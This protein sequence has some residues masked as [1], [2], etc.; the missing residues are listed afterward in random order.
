MIDDYEEENG[1]SM[2]V[3]DFRGIP[4]D[5]YIDMLD[6]IDRTPDEPAGM[7]MRYIVALT[8]CSMDDLDTVIEMGSGKDVDE[9]GDLERFIDYEDLEGCE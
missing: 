6:H 2:V 4:T 9:I 7:L 3:E 8:R 1:E 5:N